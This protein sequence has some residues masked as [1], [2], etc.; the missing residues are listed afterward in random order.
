MRHQ[1]DVVLLHMQERSEQRLGELQRQMKE[2]TQD[3]PDH[4]RVNILARAKEED[5]VEAEIRLAEEW[6]RGV[7]AV[8]H[9]IQG[10][11]LGMP[12]P[13]EAE[14]MGQVRTRRDF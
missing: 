1:L 9:A 6:Q 10:D 7:M 8:V 5:R 3:Q 4:D 11:L 12:V 2:I 13:G 14:D